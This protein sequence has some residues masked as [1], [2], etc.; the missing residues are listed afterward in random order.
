MF[1][2]HIGVNMGYFDQFMYLPKS[3]THNGRRVVIHPVGEHE[4]T[5]GMYRCSDEIHDCP[6]DILFHPAPYHAMVL[7]TDKIV[8]MTIYSK[9]AQLHAMTRLVDAAVD[10]IVPKYVSLCPSDDNTAVKRNIKNMATLNG[11]SLLIRADYG[12]NGKAVACV[13]QPLPPNI[14]DLNRDPSHR[15]LTSV[16][17]QDDPSA[18]ARFIDRGYHFVEQIKGIKDEYRLLMLPDL[19]IYCC[20]RTLK[21]NEFGF[22]VGTVAMIDEDATEQYVLLGEVEELAPYVENILR[23]I[24]PIKSHYIDF[25]S[26]DLFITVNGQWGFFEFSS[27]FALNGMHDDLRQSIM[28]SIVDYYITKRYG[29]PPTIPP[30]IGFDLPPDTKADCEDRCPPAIKP[31]PLRCHQHTHS[32]T[33]PTDVCSGFYPTYTAVN[34]PSPLSMLHWGD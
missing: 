10:F 31:E 22:P 8:P 28:K 5:Y 14:N 19:T 21:V 18:L 15:W 6:Y 2:Y 4:L 12:S 13:N 26:F 33:E 20:K 23:I 24:K 7:E 27:Q 9:V 3:Y 32:E 16:L 29:K 1:V 25:G 11:L 17:G 34:H 30:K